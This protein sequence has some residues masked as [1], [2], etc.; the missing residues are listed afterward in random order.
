MKFGTSV[1]VLRGSGAVPGT[2][3]CRRKVQGILIGARGHERRVRLVQDDPH[4]TVGW[5]RAGQIGHWAAS[6]VTK[7]KTP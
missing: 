5:N 4:D 7:R 2:P 1:W 3:G 6:T